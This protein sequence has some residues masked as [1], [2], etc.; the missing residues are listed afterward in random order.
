MQ[1]RRDKFTHQIRCRLY[2]GSPEKPHVYFMHN[3]VVFQFHKH[4]NTKDAWFQIDGGNPQ[5]WTSIYPDLVAAGVTPKGRNLRNPSAGQVIL[6]MSA[7]RDVRSV[8]IRAVSWT[9][10]ERFSISGLN[11]A[12]ASA[13]NLGCDIDQSFE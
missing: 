3:T 7:L 12:L 2:Q 8:Q 6:P 1:V 13:H 5:A 10:P 4:W 11:D 9:K